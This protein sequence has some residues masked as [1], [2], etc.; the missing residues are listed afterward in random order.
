MA[1]FLAL[2]SAQPSRTVDLCIA[3][4]LRCAAPR[5]AARVRVRPTAPAAWCPF[6]P[7][8]RSRPVHHPGQ[9]A[10]L[11]LPH[12]HHPAAAG[13]LRAAAARMPGGG[14]VPPAGAGLARTTRAGPALLQPP[15][16]PPVRLSASPLPTLP[17][18]VLPVLGDAGKHHSIPHPELAPAARAGA[19]ARGGVPARLPAPGPLASWLPNSPSQ[20]PPAPLAPCLRCSNARRR[21][22]GTLSCTARAVGGGCRARRRPLPTR[23]PAPCPM[24]QQET[25]QRKQRRQQ[26]GCTPA[27]GRAAVW[28]RRPL[29]A[30][31][32]HQ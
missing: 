15:C 24:R 17:P 20:L 10:H 16:T 1:L 12:A 5:R 8:T 26:Q 18:A 29:A 4:P 22:G 3:A 21:H 14:S 11:L 13:H 32:M 31:P 19:G 6:L 30:R 28:A 2:T 25:Q 7:C 9:R 23:A 27:R